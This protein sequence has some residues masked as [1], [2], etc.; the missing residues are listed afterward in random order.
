MH[1]YGKMGGTVVGRAEPTCICGSWE[2]QLLAEPSVH[3]YGAGG[4]AVG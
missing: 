2:E 4:I 3:V 1:V